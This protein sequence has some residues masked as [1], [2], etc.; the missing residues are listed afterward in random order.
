MQMASKNAKN[1]YIL[2]KSNII[3]FVLKIL[4]KN[5]IKDVLIINII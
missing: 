5:K 3:K 1:V 4:E 2:F